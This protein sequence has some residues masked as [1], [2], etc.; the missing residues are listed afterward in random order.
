MD[1]TQ[2]LSDVRL[3]PVVVIDDVNSAVPLARVL[4]AAGIGAVEI[5]LRS[6]AALAAIER[7]AS[8]V[9]DILVGA[10]SVRRVEQFQQIKNVGASF[11]VSPGSTDAL[12]TAANMPYVAGV[13]TPSESLKLLE[14]GYRLQKFFPAEVNGGVAA[15]KAF[16]APIP[17]VLFCPTGG[18]NANNARSYL[19]LSGVACIGGSWFVPSE[20]LAQQDF[21]A[22][23][24]LAQQAVELTNV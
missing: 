11:A 20:L 12:L 21:A 6:D 19:N 17:E 2:L 24:T 13:A 16:A 22:I 7:V 14:A 23:K 15:L 9:P 10:G 1:A 8:E 4:L 5:T 18:V 3:L